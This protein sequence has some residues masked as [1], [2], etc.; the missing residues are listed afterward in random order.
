ML[1]QLRIRFQRHRPGHRLH[2]GR[3]RLQGTGGRHPELGI[4]HLLASRREPLALHLTCAGEAMPEVQALVAKEADC[5][6]FLDFD[7]RAGE[8]VQLTIRAPES[9]TSA[10]DELFAHFAPELARTTA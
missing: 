1:L 5:C 3:T 2:L 8:P 4:R 10:A 7:L 9:A 6:T